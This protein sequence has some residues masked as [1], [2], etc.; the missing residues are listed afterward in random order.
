MKKGFPYEHSFSRNH[1]GALIK[2]RALR[3]CTVLC[4]TFPTAPKLPLAAFH[5]DAYQTKHTL[6]SF[7]L[8]GSQSVVLRVQALKKYI[9]LLSKW[10][11]NI[12]NVLGMCL[13]VMC[14]QKSCHPV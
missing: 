10:Y 12:S 7:T 1:T 6:I 8:A 9:N 2:H 14:A 13:V 5:P 4:T 11:G 3:K